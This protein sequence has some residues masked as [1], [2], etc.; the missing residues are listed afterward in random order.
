MAYPRLFCRRADDVE[1][2]T[3]RGSDD[4]E[5]ATRYVYY[6]VISF[7]CLLL[8]SVI[9]CIVTVL[10]TLASSSLP[11]FYFQSLPVVA[12]NSTST[13]VV[14]VTFN[15]SNPN[16]LTL[17]STKGEYV[18]SYSGNALGS[19][20]FSFADIGSHHNGTVTAPTRIYS[21]SGSTYEEL[22]QERDRLVGFDVGMRVEAR[23]KMWRVKF[24]TESFLVSC[25]V[26]VDKLTEGSKV[27]H[28]ACHSYH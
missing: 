6:S 4:A 27:T 26:Y 3:R 20:A 18:I 1:A 13:L 17:H 11:L 22:V 19:G 14:P 5:A 12:N 28:S 21:S 8:L 2:A 7:C 10:F 16:R 9:A 25:R 24:N 23:L 15:V